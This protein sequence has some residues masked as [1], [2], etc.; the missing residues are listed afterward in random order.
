VALIEKSPFLGGRTAMLDNVAPTGEKASDLVSE[1]GQSVLKDPAITV[2]TCSQVVGFEGYIG[3]FNLTVRTQPPT[4]DE[5]NG[6]L[7]RLSESGKGTQE[8]VPFAGIY[9]GGIP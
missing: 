8:F 4:A 6:K 9:A 3:N 7:K 5:E 1:L 2:H